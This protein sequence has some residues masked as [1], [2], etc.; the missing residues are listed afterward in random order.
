TIVEFFDPACTTCAEFYPL[1]TQLLAQYPGKVKVEMR[2]A[3]LHSGSDQVVAMLEAAHRQGKFWQALELLFANQRRWVIE[4]K[5]QPNRARALLE[6][7]ELDRQRF[8][9]DLNRP[10]VLQVVQQD[11]LDGQ[12]LAVRATPEFFVNG[13]PMPSFGYEQLSTLL[14][15]AVAAAY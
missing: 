4:H 1:V 5:S 12:R 14:K 6:T 8:A 2:Y 9:E 10:E 15:E 11:V 3:P 13:R 7:L